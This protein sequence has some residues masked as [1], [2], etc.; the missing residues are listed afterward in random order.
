M[1][2][3]FNTAPPAPP[4]PP[5]PGAPAPGGDVPSDTGKILAA[6]G[7]LVGIVAL[8]AILIE[9][10]KN[11]R[12]VR[13]H[14]VQALGIWVGWIAISIISAIPVIGWIISAVGWIALLVFSIMGAV[15]AFQ[16]EMWEM[17]VVHG[18]VKQFI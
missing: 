1:S 11:E 9:P 7:Y 6:V 17:P 16:G 18:L 14:A 13:H 3:D 5:V 12:F 2:D 10:Y 4:A 8:I 15:K